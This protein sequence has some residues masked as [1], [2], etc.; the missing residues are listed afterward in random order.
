MPN[1]LTRIPDIPVPALPGW[2]SPVVLVADVFMV[3]MISRPATGSLRNTWVTPGS[4]QLSAV[5]ALVTMPVGV[6]LAYRGISDASWTATVMGAALLM[7]GVGCLSVL[8]VG[9]AQRRYR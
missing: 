6:F 4:I 8:T 5:L 1:R 3:A 2:V 7:L 9:V